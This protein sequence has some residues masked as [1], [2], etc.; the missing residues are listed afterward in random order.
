MGP[1]LFLL[2]SSRTGGN[3]ELLARAAAEQL[4]SNVEQ[5]WI[6]LSEYPLV[7]FEDVR[8]EGERAYEMPT[9]HARTLLNATLTADHLV[10]A[11]PVYWYSLPAPAKLYL[12]HWSHWMRVPG[13]DFRKRMQGKRIS[14]TTSMAGNDVL[15]AAPLITSLQL[16][17][18]Y[19]GMEWGGYV[20]AHANA[21]GDVLQQPDVLAK[22]E[23]LLK[24]AL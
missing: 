17:A 18:T 24:D 23:R 10:F 5:H 19:M 16:T 1:F 3:S 20:L 14:L 21:A 22:A 15:E 7:A 13:L 2:A 9:G 8:H 12:D 6:R 4:P 11:A